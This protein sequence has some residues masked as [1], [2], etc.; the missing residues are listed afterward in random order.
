[1]NKTTNPVVPINEGKCNSRNGSISSVSVFGG[2]LDVQNEILRPLNCS[3]NDSV[4]NGDVMMVDNSKK[5]LI[6]PDSVSTSFQTL[7][8]DCSLDREFSGLTIPIKFKG[9][10]VVNIENIPHRILPNNKELIPQSIKTV[11][12]AVTWD[13]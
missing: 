10:N 4:S 3:L 7:T 8:P 11:L 2:N 6:E 12:T 5:R 1:M 13:S 9:K